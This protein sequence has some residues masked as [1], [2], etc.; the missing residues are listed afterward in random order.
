[1]QSAA[2]HERFPPLD[3]P[4]ATFVPC[5][6]RRA[7]LH[8]P[9]TSGWLLAAS[10]SQLAVAVAVLWWG[11]SAHPV[12]TVP[13]AVSIA[14][15]LLAAPWLVSVVVLALG[16]T[17]FRHLERRYVAWLDGLTAE[18]RVLHGRQVRARLLE[19]EAAPRHWVVPADW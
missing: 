9:V 4:T 17:R 16:R 18:Q 15:V 8:G 14:G 6:H 13:A 10:V 7:G 2:T 1:M 11:L 19:H 5:G 3:A 12:L